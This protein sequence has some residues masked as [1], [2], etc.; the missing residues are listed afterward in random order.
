[1]AGAVRDEA[2]GRL[3]EAAVRA[4][5]TLGVRGDLRG[6]FREAHAFV[7]VKGAAPGTALEGQGPR[8]IELEVGRIELGAGR[9]APAVGLELTGFA[10]EPAATADGAR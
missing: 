8:R 6:R 3:T 10:L 2:S 9:P 1:V 4:L 7:G 5:G